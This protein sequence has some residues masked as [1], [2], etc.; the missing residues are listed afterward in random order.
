MI[1]IQDIKCLVTFIIVA[2]IVR[3]VIT[4]Y[5]TYDHYKTIKETENIFTH[6]LNA[7]K[8]K[9]EIISPA[10]ILSGLI[11][12]F[13]IKKCCNH[14]MNIVLCT[15]I[16]FYLIGLY[17]TL[18]NVAINAPIAYKAGANTPDIKSYNFIFNKDIQQRIILSSIPVV[19]AAFIVCKLF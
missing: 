2:A 8:E 12:V 11:F 1:E 3:Y 5:N 10:D 13:I 18:S 6:S 19:I 15:F 14:K 17:A 4:F 16:L 7:L 9:T